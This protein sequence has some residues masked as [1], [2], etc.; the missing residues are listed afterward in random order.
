MKILTIFFPIVIA[1]ML[2]A[3]SSNKSQV[4]PVDKSSSQP[5]SVFSR[6]SRPNKALPKAVIYR[7]NGDYIDNVAVNLNSQR[8]ALI[9]FP[10]PTD[11]TS[12]STP[13]ELGDGWLFDRRGGIGINSAFLSYT[14]SQYSALKS[15]PSSLQLF[16]DII[17]GSAVIQCISTPVP[18]SEAMANPDI[19]KQYIP[20]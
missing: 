18:L 7:T 8:T 13:V 4:R 16:Y 2:M 9:S 12:H 19:L 1:V 6:S 17:P 14:Y 15:T 20:R 10:A 11:I 3:C 5:V